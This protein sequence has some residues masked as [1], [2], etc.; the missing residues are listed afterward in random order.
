[1]ASKRG[2][3]EV[4]DRWD[5]TRCSRDPCCPWNPWQASAAIV[6]QDEIGARW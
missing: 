5:N 4:D 2:G 1:V 6:G 3:L